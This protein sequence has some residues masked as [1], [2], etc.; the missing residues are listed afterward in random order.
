MRVK[1]GL[2]EGSESACMCFKCVETTN[3]INVLVSTEIPAT[4]HAWPKE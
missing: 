4:Y 2:W 1:R 3:E